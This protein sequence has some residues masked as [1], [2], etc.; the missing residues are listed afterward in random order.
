VEDLCG[1]DARIRETREKLAVAV[2]AAGTSL[3][4]LFG[5]GPI[6]AAAVIG[7]VR[8]VSA[9]AAGTPSPL[10]TGPRRSRCPSASGTS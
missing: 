1:I 9:S 6:I 10:T 5:A 4:G 2:Q 8:D 7:D 3:T